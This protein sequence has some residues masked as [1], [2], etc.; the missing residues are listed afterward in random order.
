LSYFQPG[1]PKRCAADA[2]VTA[3][4]D[5]ASL[6]A[7]VKRFREPFT[8]TDAGV[9]MQAYVPGNRLLVCSGD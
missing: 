8:A 1:A 9:S 4:D 3:S 2:S 7:I 6:E 5:N